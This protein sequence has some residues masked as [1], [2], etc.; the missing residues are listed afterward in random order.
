M[1]GRKEKKNKYLPTSQA[2]LFAVYQTSLLKDI[3]IFIDIYVIG[4]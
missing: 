4:K 3:M 2:G 1:E